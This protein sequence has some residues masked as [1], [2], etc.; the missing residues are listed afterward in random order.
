MEVSKLLRSLPELHAHI[1]SS[2]APHVYWH[3]ANSEGYKLPK[4]DYHEFVKHIV[5]S[6]DRKMS[7]KE[8]LDTI[9]HPI[10]DKLSTGAVALEK[11]VYETFS[12][13][14]R[15]NHITLYE[16]RGNPMKHNREGEVDLD[17]AIM[18]MLRG[19]ERALLEYPKLRAGIIFCLDRQ[20]TFKQ[21]EVIVNKA[22]KYRSRGIIG[23]DFSNY[24]KTGFHFKDYIDLVAKARSAGLKVTAHSGETDDTNDLWECLETINP[25]R[26]GHGIKAAYDK[27]LMHELSKR[28]IVL[29]V[30]PLSNLM[31]KAAKDD[32]EMNFIL[33]TLFDNGVHFSLNTDWPETIKDGH[34]W[35]QYQYVIERNMLSSTQIE[36]LINWGYDASFIPIKTGESNLYL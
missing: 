4:R 35:E 36:Q 12:G 14:Y 25:D 19:M 8:Y 24:N 5:L 27:D 29:E 1:G 17:H 2:I 26:I 22:I 30:C 9:Y 34:L 32:Q 18:A 3:I 33:N 16:L 6:P 20:F 11:G 31:T 10:L 13:A 7:L 21:N 23:I 15:S 28:N